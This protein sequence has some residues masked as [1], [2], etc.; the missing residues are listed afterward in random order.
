M[1]KQKLIAAAIVFALVIYVD[2]AFILQ[3]QVKALS[4]VK[5][6]NLKLAADIQTVQKD[7]NAMRE[8]QH[9]VKPVL[10]VPKKIVSEGE[11]LSLVARISQIA[12][13]NMVKVAQ[14]NPVKN[15]RPDLKAGQNQPA[16]GEV[17]IKLD[18]SCGYH[19]LGGFLNDLENSEY[20][21]SAEDLNIRPDFSLGQKENVLLTLKTYVKS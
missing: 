15:A 20:A 17:F 6:K 14:I 5:T 8:N 2:F 1:N 4:A 7:L 18:L 10:S 11:L 16:Y 13:D 3:A 21:L 12:K 19:N 9:K